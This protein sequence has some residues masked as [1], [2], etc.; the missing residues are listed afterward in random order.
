[1]QALGMLQRMAQIPPY[2]AN[3][4]ELVSLSLHHPPQL[5]LLGSKGCGLP[6]DHSTPHLL[7]ETYLM[8]RMVDVP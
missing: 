1:M 7:T 3:R 4:R 5:G 2:Q 8:R 6:D